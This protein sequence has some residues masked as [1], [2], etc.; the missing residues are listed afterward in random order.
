[1]DFSKIYLPSDS[2]EVKN[3]LTF[4]DRG[5][6]YQIKKLKQN[7]R[8]ANSD[9]DSF[10]QRLDQL[11]SEMQKCLLF[12]DDSG[13]P[14]TYSGLYKDLQN[15]FHWDLTNNL[16]KLDEGKLIPW[17]SQPKL[18][19]DYQSEAVEELIKARH[20]AIELP[21]G[22]GKSRIIY[23]LCKRLGLKTIIA[24]PSASITDQLYKEF[25]KLFGKKYIG[26]YGDGKKEIDKLFT[27]ATAQALVRVE[28]GS[29]QWNNLT[30]T[31]VLIWDECFPYD[32]KIA[33]EKGPIR[34]STLHNNFIKGKPLPKVLSFN[35]IEKKFEYK[36]ITNTWK[37]EKKDNMVK[38]RCSNS[39]FSCTSDHKILTNLGWVKAGDLT[40]KHFILGNVNDKK[41]SFSPEY[42]GDS[43]QY[44]LG[45]Y[46]GDGSISIHKNGI[47]MR[48]IHSAKQLNYL[49][50]GANLLGIKNIE[51]IEKNGYAKK[52]AYRFSTKLF[53]SKLPF[54]KRKKQITKEFLE[55][56]N[57][58][59][60]AVWFMDDGY[61][62]G[63]NRGELHTSSFDD[64]SQEIIVTWFKNKGI[65]CRVAVNKGYKYI[66]FSK[67]GY[68][69]L[70]KKI[71]NYIHPSLSY[72]ISKR[73]QNLVGTYKWIP[74]KSKYGYSQVVS[75]EKFS[76]NLP[77]R[78]KYLSNL[79][80]IEVEDNHNFIVSSGATGIV[81]HNCHTTPAETFEKVVMN[82][83][84]DCYYR[85]FVSATQ[86]RTDGS[87]M[88]LKGITGP[89]VYR[90][91]FKELV[92][93]GYLSRPFFKIFKVQSHGFSGAND[94]N[95]ETRQ[96]LYLNPNVNKLAGEIA[97]KCVN[98]L[99]RQTVILIDEFAQFMQL[100]NYITVPF[101]FAH[102]GISNRQNADG[103]NLK[104][105]VPKEYWK[106][107]TE[108][109]VERFNK[110]ETKLIIGT[111]AIS[112]GVD[113]Q[114]TGALIYLQGGTSEIQVKQGIGRATRVT[115]NKKDAFIFD[116]KVE[117]SPS[118][119]RHCNARM[120]IYNQLGEVQ[121]IG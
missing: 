7:Y 30:K 20:G 55:N 8:W 51:F 118:M 105:I 11:K 47:R 71:S 3:F 87:E 97:H 72:K 69:L 96:Q 33:T 110:G 14:Y 58:K 26:K 106:S 1:M 42:L 29:E 90:K 2:E 116:F 16:N 81:A 75:V 86:I 4:R 73:F 78:K 82:L 15:R 32:T 59:G 107:D 77:K 102:G 5:V 13:N 113:L 43:E 100:K 23:E 56:V 63:D 52:P 17:A 45:S 22:S 84:K 21:T 108:A 60:L 10:N 80:D 36:T 12:Y 57:D 99:N 49:K 115:D 53:Y 28:E 6:D 92:E 35:E 19:R 34:I 89:T 67:E 61:G 114:P 120:A 9:P 95:K 62:N 31:D 70:S 38:V 79:Y 88:I 104:D 85:F 64:Q 41:S 66:L 68:N 24:T 76:F 117:G 46:L 50:W 44:I 40:K 65:E 39:T 83:L 37:R 18:L 112:T 54:E 48:V 25:I 94:I 103:T 74:E 111:S 27:V 98:L 109:I 101:E 121:E 119:E 93:K 91:D